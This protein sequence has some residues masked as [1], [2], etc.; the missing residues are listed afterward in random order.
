MSKALPNLGPDERQ[1][2]LNCARL[3]LDGPLLHQ[4]EELLQ[5]RLEW[6]GVLFFAELHSVAPL[7]DHHLKRFEWSDLIPAEARRKLLQLSH[8]AGY[9]NRQYSQALQGLLKVFGEAG[10]PIIVLKGL[11]LV[12]LIYGD[13]RL[14]QLT[15]LDL[16]IPVEKLDAA[17]S[18]VSRMGYVNRK[19][20]PVQPLFRSLYSQLELVKQRDF[21]VQILLQWGVLNRPRIHAIDIRRFWAEAKFARISGRDVLIPSPTDLVLY[22][23]LQPDKHGYL[24]SCALHVDDR[25]GFIF[26]IW[27][28]NRLVRFTDIY[29]VIRHYDGAIDWGVLTERARA[30]G[31]EGSVYSALHWVTRL[32]GPLTPPWVLE[33][34]RPPS[35]RRVRRWLFE[36]LAREP[37][38]SRSGMTAKTVFRA[39]WLSWQKRSQLRLIRLLD[40]IEFIFPRLDEVKL[41]HRVH[42]KRAALAAYLFHSGKSLL[43][44]SV[45]FLP[46]IYC[47][48][49]RRTSSAGL[50]RET[51]FQEGSRR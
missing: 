23:C 14:R 41:R 51:P 50:P 46:W 38:W 35:P 25:P 45:G 39:W 4:T 28:D 16:L 18:L 12:E 15:K 2:I 20:R 33:S 6:E 36:A 1:L 21:E 32:F 48:L 8:R 22:L 10:I 24:N 3:H 44:C 40:L 29:E 7:L 42:S 37:K 49:I 43:R 26:D 5:K 47:L 13:L 30:S 19:R 17:R 34:L 11:S 27:T 31:I 9:Q